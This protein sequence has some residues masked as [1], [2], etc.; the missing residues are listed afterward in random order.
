MLAVS[1][2]TSLPSPTVPIC[3]SLVPADI[4][5]T[6]FINV[7]KQVPMA[8][9]AGE[10]AKHEYPILASVEAT[11]TPVFLSVPIPFQRK[12]LYKGHLDHL[13]IHGFGVSRFS[14]GFP[15]QSWI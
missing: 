11:A 2:V 12:R 13:G 7:D 14:L 10:D 6:F 4:D 15:A 3:E 8:R 9:S 5:L 1:E